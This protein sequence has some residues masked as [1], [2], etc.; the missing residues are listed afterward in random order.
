MVTGGSPP[1]G[2]WGFPAGGRGGTTWDGVGGGG[3]VLDPDVD[4]G[5]DS[6]G[7]PGTDVPVRSDAAG[8]AVSPHPA[9]TP[10]ASAAVVAISNALMAQGR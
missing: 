5:T 10:S 9:S 6:D 8:A 7:N 1:D 2:F 4:S 3:G